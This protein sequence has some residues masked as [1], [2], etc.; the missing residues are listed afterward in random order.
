[1][2]GSIRNPAHF[3]GVYGHKPTYG[4]V[5]IDGHIPPP[6]GVHAEMDFAVLGPLARSA[7]DLQLVLDV[8]AGPDAARSRAWRLE[9][10]P[11]RPSLRLATW[12]DDP[13]CRVDSA[14][15]SVLEDA[16]QALRRAGH[17]VAGETRPPVP[18]GEIERVMQRLVQGMTAGF[19][20][21]DDF[22]RAVRDAAGDGSDNHTLWARDVAGSARDWSIANGRRHE[23]RAMYAA[24]FEDNDV[25]LTPV[26]PMPAFP[27]NFEDP[28]LDDVAPWSAI[29]GLMWLPATV[30]PVGRTPEGLPVGVQIIGPF[31]EDH[32]TIAAARRICE[33]TSGFVPPARALEF[34]GRVGNGTG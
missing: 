10:P 4:I 31:L 5:P 2:L 24:F 16:A 30:A 34:S 21:Q 18:L 27:H 25:L 28:D 33:L 22:R 8:M 17:A 12:F 7:A 26:C 32:T 23:L 29:A 13:R 19:M 14:V 9:L 15:L 11:A 3:C 6:P 20:P 1:L